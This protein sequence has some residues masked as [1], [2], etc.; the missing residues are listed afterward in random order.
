M[1]VMPVEKFE[2]IVAVDPGDLESAAVWIDVATFKPVEVFEGHNAKLREKLQDGGRSLE[3]SRILV[4]EYT[5][6]YTMQMASKG[7]KPGR[8]FVPRQVV[9][10]AIE[11]GRFI[12]CWGGGQA[13]RWILFSR[14]DVKK[15][16]LGRASG[17]DTE[18][19]AAVVDRYGGDLKTAKGVK[20]K[21]GPL[22]GF[23]G[24]HVYAALG[25]GIAYLEKLGFWPPAKFDKAARVY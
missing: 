12:E 10:T 14:T 9:D 3:A 16:L 2:E 15:H 22:Y 18:V 13:E 17:N 4:V 24:N 6:P 1:P 8:A 21:P 5:P 19:R 11:L 20:A 25:L 23:S 7:G